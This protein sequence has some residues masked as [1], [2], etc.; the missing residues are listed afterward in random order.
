MKHTHFKV[1]E[2]DSFQHRTGIVRSDLAVKLW[3]KCWIMVAK[4]MEMVFKDSFSKE[5]Y[6][7][8]RD[9]LDKERKLLSQVILFDL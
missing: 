7:E 4:T 9:C 2:L 6:D 5:D 1:S 3:I 8:L